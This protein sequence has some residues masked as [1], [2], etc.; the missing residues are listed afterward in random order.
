[1]GLPVKLIVHRGFVLSE[2][3]CAF[4]YAI[5]EFWEAHTFLATFSVSLLVCFV[6]LICFHCW[7]H[8]RRQRGSK[9][10][11]YGERL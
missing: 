1:M 11:R 6:L 7:E 2:H 10:P 4:G 9:T 5:N 8:V 3:A